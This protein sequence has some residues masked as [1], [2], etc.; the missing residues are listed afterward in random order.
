VLR[1]ERGEFERARAHSGPGSGTATVRLK[2]SQVREELR[3]HGVVPRRRESGDRHGRSVGT[4][5]TL[6]LQGAASTLA[7]LVD[8]SVF[9]GT[10]GPSPDNG[11]HQMRLQVGVDKGGVWQVGL[12][13]PGTSDVEADLWCID[14]DEAVQFIGRSV[15]RDM[16]IGSPKRRGR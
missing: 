8:G 15:S 3:R 6:Q 7:Q 11:D 10:P 2:R 16:K 1:G 14:R 13:N 5:T 4:T 9:V 12:E